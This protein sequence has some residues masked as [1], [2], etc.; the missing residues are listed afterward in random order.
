MEHLVSIKKKHKI[1]VPTTLNNKE[2]AKSLI[3][4]SSIYFIFKE[5]P[6][7]NKSAI[8]N[9]IKK[10]KLYFKSFSCIKKT[11]EKKYIPLFLVS[12]W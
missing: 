2:W 7:L 10:D 12:Y 3:S 11:N 6:L 5:K 9:I 1:I 8:N 4:L